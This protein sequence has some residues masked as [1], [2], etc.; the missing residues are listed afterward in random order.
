MA[1]QYDVLIIGGFGHVGLPLGIVLADAG[2]QVGLLDLNTA[3]RPTIEK[4]IMPFIEHGAE[5]IMK[6]V[7]GKSLHVCDGIADVAKAKTIIITIGTPVDEYL[8]PVIKPLFALADSLMPHVKSDQCLVLRSTVFPGTTRSLLEHF[9]KHGKSVHMSNCPE[10]IVQGFAIQE[11]KELPQV[12]SGF[13]PEAVKMAGDLFKKIGVETIEVSVEE[14]ECTKLF[15]NA[16]RYMQFAAANQ[17]YTFATER[18][19]DYG[20]IHHAMTHHYKR[21]NIPKPGFA[22]GPCLFKDTMQL[23]AADRSHFPL[24]HAAMIVNEGLPSFL[25]EQLEKSGTELR[26]K[27]VG[28]LGMAFKADIDDTRDSLSFKLKKLLQFKGA[29]VLCS[30][31]FV[32]DK[33][34]VPKEELLKKC[35]VVIVGVPHSAYKGLRIPKEVRTVDLWN[36]LG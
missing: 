16:W 5:P 20:K 1:S 36:I 34:F 31:E 6:R 21:G 25:V 24:G 4:G 27:T 15:L 28:I 17:F 12:I 30:D 9:R 3:L 29:E 32:K 19:L 11:L 10:R 7:I 33:G 23:A 18:G 35:S 26:G 13:T 8:S 22:A 2:L 14:A